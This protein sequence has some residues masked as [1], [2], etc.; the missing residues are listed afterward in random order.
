MKKEYLKPLFF[1]HILLI[2]YSLGGICSKLAG[3][4]DFFS[5][6]FFLFY[7]VVL[8]ILF[9][10]AILWQQIL[11]KLPLVTAFANKAIVVIW[12]IIWG[13]IF[14]DENFSICKLIGAIIIIIGVY[15][16]VSSDEQK[17]DVK[18]L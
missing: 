18:E 14:F 9:L 1:L 13:N 11:K 7:G 2:I 3:Q 8:L 5:V 4:Q 16:V 10:Y 15:L 17:E 6:R 12:S